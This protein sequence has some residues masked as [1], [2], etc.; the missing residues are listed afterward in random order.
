MKR[1]RR[2]RLAKE[3][4]QGELAEKAGL[5]RQVISNLERGASHGTPE[6]WRRLAAVLGV[7]VDELL[8]PTD[9]PKVLAPLSPASG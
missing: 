9:G 6:T 4:N 3:M 7:T 1:L 5:S 8:E 2:I